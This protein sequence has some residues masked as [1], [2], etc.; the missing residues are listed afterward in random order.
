LVY[1]IWFL[2]EVVTLV[3]GIP[4]LALEYY[5]V[6]LLAT[7]MK[8]PKTLGKQNVKLTS[9][10][11]V[12]ILIATFNERFVIERSLEA[13]KHLDYPKDRIQVVVADD[14]NDQTTSII[15]AKVKDLVNSG[16]RAL[17]SRRPSREYFK[18]GALNKAMEK[19][20]GDYVLLLDADSM[21]SP[22]VLTKGIESLQGQPRTAFVSYRY[23]HYNRDYNTVTRLFALSQD[24]GDTLSK[25]GAYRIDAPFSFQGG[26]TLVRTKDLKEV[27]LWSNQR[28]ADDTDISIKMYLAGKRGIYLSNVKIMS[29]DPST[30][31]AWKKQVA[32]TSQGWWRCI[33]NYWKTIVTAPGVSA[34]KKA[35]LILMLM[36][37]FSSLS[38]IIVTFLSTF[39]VVFNLIPPSFSIFNSPFY[40]AMVSIPFAVSM[41]S[42]AWALRVQGL[43]TAR[44]LVLIPMLGYA[45][46][47]MLVLGSL[48]FFYGVFDRMGFFVYRTPKSGAFKEMTKNTYFQHLTNDRNSIVEV[49]LGS[50]GIFFAWFVFIHGVWFLAISM[51]GF[52]LFTLKSMN[53]TR[54]FR[55][56]QRQ[57][58][59]YPTARSGGVITGRSDP[60]I[61]MFHLYSRSLR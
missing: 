17:V 53:L 38:W 54:Y 36:A 44:N 35:G 49:I 40:V 47:G 10:P 32:R 45:S 51:L 29:E 18:C 15:D 13:V 5:W 24:I 56:R 42:G 43:M 27:G 50:A 48:G 22:E 21:V 57:P 61:R 7:S 59:F 52:G 20:E 37:P 25:M 39:T 58:G 11:L 3:L 55:L 23:G 33:A 14:S 60:L 8:Y 6:I 28:I 12:S 26:Q 16:I 9:F 19:V 34:R 31:E 41:A 30:L 1:Q 46:G 4:V 2:L